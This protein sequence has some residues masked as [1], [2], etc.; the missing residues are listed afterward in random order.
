MLYGPQDVEFDD[1]L[2]THL[3][4]VIINK[5]RR[6]ESFLLTWIDDSSVGGGRASMWMAR[7]V[8][9]YFKYRGSR[10]PSLNPQWLRAMELAAES[11]RGLLVVNED[12][13]PARAGRAPGQR[14]DRPARREAVA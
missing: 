10:V 2:L 6:H 9:V 3:E 12:G 4:I 7:E 5:F 14:T 8:P 11:P 13:T 1:R